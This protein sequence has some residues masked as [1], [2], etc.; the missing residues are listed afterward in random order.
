[1]ND[2]MKNILN[3]KVEPIVVRF[4]ISFYNVVGFMKANPLPPNPDSSS[5][6]D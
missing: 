4:E 6:T 3:P 1:M 5:T 2:V